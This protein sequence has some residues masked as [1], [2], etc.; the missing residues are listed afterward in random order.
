MNTRTFAFEKLEKSGSTL[1]GV[2]SLITESFEIEAMTGANVEQLYHNLAS[3]GLGFATSCG[4]NDGNGFN[5]DVHHDVSLP[6][7][8]YTGNNVKLYGTE[9]STSPIDVLGYAN[10]K[11]EVQRLLDIYK[12]ASKNRVHY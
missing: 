4:V 12:V 5:E 8:E 2:A 9:T 1:K 3:H 6:S 7:Y 11:K 10:V